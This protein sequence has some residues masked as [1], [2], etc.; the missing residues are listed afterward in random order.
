MGP[1]SPSEPPGIMQLLSPFGLLIICAPQQAAALFQ[2]KQCAMELSWMSGTS[3]VT[4]ALWLLPLLLPL[5][6]HG[7][8][9]PQSGEKNGADE[10]KA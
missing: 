6:P 5:A 8:T 1:E 7:L 2:T 9:D 4:T 3:Q 10:V